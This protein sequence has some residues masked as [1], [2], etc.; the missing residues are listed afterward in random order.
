MVKRDF[1]R[2][3]NAKK[4]RIF[5]EKNLMKIREEIVTSKNN[6]TV[7]R[8]ASLKDK[9]GRREL[10]SFFIEGEKLT[11][12]AIEN[13]LPITHIILLDTKKDAILPRIKC[14]LSEK[15]HNDVEIIIV[16][17]DVFLKIS[18][19]KAPQGVIT[20]IKY[21][22]FF[23]KLDIIYKEEFFLKPD[24]RAVILCS[25]QDPGNLGSV[26]RSAVA[27]GVEHVILTSDCADVYNTKTVR[28]AMGSLFK[29]KVTEIPS[30]PELVSTMRKS[31][32]RVFAAE[33]R[34]GAVSLSDLELF[35]SDVFIIGN[36]GHGIP[37][38]VS[39][40]CDNSVYIPISEN[41]ESLNASVAAAILIWEQNK[42]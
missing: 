29:V 21:L 22:D 11:L 12:E 36:E 28:S 10:E 40:L 18:S 27:F 14:L 8:I 31:G 42:K 37:S 33:L 16:T 26:I 5:K 32:R 17:E 15:V 13:A 2:T 19:E 3:K 25:L 30:L 6:P 4:K 41:T 1:F 7:K 24:E 20:V 39:L 9:K 23:Q 35:G 38:E 34:E